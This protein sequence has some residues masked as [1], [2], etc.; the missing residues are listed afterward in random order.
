MQ[1]QK[2]I[3]TNCIQSMHDCFW[4]QKEW[5]LDLFDTDCEE[6]D[7]FMKVTK[8]FNNFTVKQTI[9]VEKF[10]IIKTQKQSP[11]LYPQTDQNE[12]NN[13]NS[14]SNI[15][16]ATGATN[17]ATTTSTATAMVPIALNQVRLNTAGAGPNCSHSHIMHHPHATMFGFQTFLEPK[18]EPPSL[19]PKR[20][21]SS[22]NSEDNNS[23][24]HNSFQGSNRYSSRNSSQFNSNGINVVNGINNI[25][26][27]GNNTS[28][29]NSGNSVERKRIAARMN[30]DTAMVCLFISFWILV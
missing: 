6:K 28:G 7:Y 27:S 11:Q 30:D 10:A 29:N 21:Y 4:E 26:I 8:D 24:S 20:E 16:Q 3:E 18:L 13:N 22:P 12:T 25:N 1:K 23:M 17:T 5:Y 19:S 14:K 2:L 15:L 9:K